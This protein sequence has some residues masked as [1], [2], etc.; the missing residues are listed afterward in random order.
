[1]L[2]I[3]PAN[4]FPGTGPNGNG[5]PV[6]ISD[7]GQ[8]LRNVKTD[9]CIHC[10]QIGDKATRT[11]PVDLGHFNSAPKRGSAVCNPDKLAAT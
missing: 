2:K 5:M 7:Q 8:W 11:F 1:M 9:G 6:A 3:P 10:H 4:M